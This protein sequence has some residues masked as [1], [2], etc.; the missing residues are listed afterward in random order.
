MNKNHLIALLIVTNTLLF[1]YGVFK[2]TQLYNKHELLVSCHE[3]VTIQYL[4]LQSTNV[5]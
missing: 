3:T 2:S 4:E 5:K 1:G